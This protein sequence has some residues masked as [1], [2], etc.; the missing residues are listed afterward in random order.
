MSGPMMDLCL[1]FDLDS[2]DD[3]SRDDSDGEGAVGVGLAVPFN[4]RCE[5][6]PFVVY[7]MHWNDFWHLHGRTVWERAFW[8]LFFP[9]QP[10]I[11]T[12]RVGNLEPSVLFVSW[13]STWPEILTAAG[14][15]CAPH[16]P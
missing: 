10:N 4:S 5:E 8:Q 16:T 3:E 9:V 7:L 13:R 12:E 1:I 14:W 11:H 6:Y 15:D 2:E